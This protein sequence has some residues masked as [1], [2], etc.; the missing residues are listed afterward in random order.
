MNTVVVACEERGRPE[1]ET[2]AEFVIEDLCRDPGQIDAVRGAERLVL[3]LHH[4]RYD[5]PALQRAAR[6]I[7]VDPLGLQIVEM[8]EDSPIGSFHAHLA[9]VVARAS[10]FEGSLPDQSK[11]ILNRVTTRRG[12]F[13]PLAPTYIAAPFID[14]QQCVASDGCRACVGVCPEEAYVWRN[15]QIEYD[16]DTCVPCGRCVTGC[17]AG[18]IGNPSV[19]PAMIEAQVRAAI[20]ASDSSV[21]IRFVC[22]RGSIVA[23]AGWLDVVVPCTSMVPATWLLACLLLGAAGA[24]AV[25]C[26]QC[27]CSLG[28]DETANGANHLASTVVKDADL[29]PRIT[30]GTVLGNTLSAAQAEGL[31]DH[32]AAAKVVEAFASVTTG[33]VDASDPSANLGIVEIDASS[34]TLCGQCAKTC[35][36]GA[37]METYHGDEVSIAFDPTLCV[38]CSQCLSSC[39]EIDNGAIAVVGKYD[40]ASLAG[41][42]RILNQGQVATC[43][44][45]GKAFAPMS[46]M[47]RIA[48]LLGPEFDATLSVVG[49]RCLDCR[50]R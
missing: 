14:Q 40:S 4:G 36:T 1:I 39:P 31:F 12:F 18:A 30:S 21:G 43:E 17:P 22:S 42:P 35:P 7:D 10:E 48:E 9:G 41:E 16:M 2:P 29:D 13:R 11:P 27:G 37:L 6:S 46:M 32:R 3:I 45:C 33:S 26:G 34:C 25:P 50:G 19:T 15:G 20:G 49:S 28:L 24:T 44:V 23:S 8:S 38:N 5:L 47:A